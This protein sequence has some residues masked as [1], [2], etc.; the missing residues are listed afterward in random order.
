MHII[1]T[2]PIVLNG[3]RDKIENFIIVHSY[4]FLTLL[5]A[6][7]SENYQRNVQYDAYYLDG[8]DISEEIENYKTSIDISA[9][10]VESFQDALNKIHRKIESVE[11]KIQKKSEEDSN[12]MHDSSIYIFNDL[13][14]SIIIKQY[15]D[16][17]FRSSS[18]PLTEY[19]SCFNY[20]EYMGLESVKQIAAN[21]KY[22]IGIPY[23]YEYDPIAFSFAARNVVG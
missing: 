13:Q 14:N 1:T 8:M 7:N 18:V 17:L 19:L 21:L 12:L 10:K 3:V 5:H 20:A 2:N 23:V 6:P 4:D 15:L 22:T 16:K 9:I 11:Y